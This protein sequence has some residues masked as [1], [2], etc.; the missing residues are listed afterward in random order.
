MF[1]WMLEE[2]VYILEHLCKEDRDGCMVLGHELLL[3]ACRKEHDVIMMSPTA[4]G[5]RKS[6]EIPM[7]G[8]KTKE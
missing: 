1:L 6:L 3:L 7:W 5:K 2:F 4:N 8:Y